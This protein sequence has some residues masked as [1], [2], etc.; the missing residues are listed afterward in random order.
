MTLLYVRCAGERNG[1]VAAVQQ[2]K[3]PCELQTEE[4]GNGE[5]D[6]RLLLILCC[7]PAENVRYAVC[8]EEAGVGADGEAFM[9]ACNTKDA[10][11]GW[12]GSSGQNVV[13]SVYSRVLLS[14]NFQS[15]LWGS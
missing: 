1:A 13:V 2:E 9:E 7:S 8:V 12:G 10:G 3:A 14:H 15:Q 6:S 4:G 5:W 11:R